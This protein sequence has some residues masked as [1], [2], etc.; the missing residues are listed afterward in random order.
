MNS[1]AEKKFLKRDF[2]GFLNDTSNTK[3]PD[4]IL[5]R[6]IAYQALDKFEEAYKEYIKN[7]IIVEKKSLISSCK[8]FFILLFELKKT[9]NLIAEIEHFKDAPYVNQETEEFMQN[10]DKYVND[11][12]EYYNYHDDLTF[13]EDELY[14]FFCSKNIDEQFYAISKLNNLANKGIVCTQ[15]IINFFN[16]FPNYTL[17]HGMLIEYL[18][19]TQCGLTVNFKKGSKYYSIRYEDYSSY[20]FKFKSEFG[21][22]ID[23][24]SKTEKNMSVIHYVLSVYLLLFLYIFPLQINEKDY[25]NFLAAMIKRSGQIYQINLNEDEFYNGLKKQDKKLDFFIEK[26]S[27]IEELI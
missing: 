24:F 1:E 3:N 15:I 11:L 4:L 16:N 14:R 7:R 10:L 18:V 20:F 23:E 8:L 9:D 13:D 19:N 6:I 27:K 17:M 5:Y 12:K 22:L 26:L 21:L 2:I 25:D